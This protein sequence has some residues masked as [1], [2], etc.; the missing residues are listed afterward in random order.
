[1]RQVR[2]SV[3]AAAAAV[4]LLAGA[5]QAA[6]A[7]AAKPL[8]AQETSIDGVSAE[9]VEVMRRDGVLTVKLRYRNT[10]GAPTRV[11][12]V[13]GSSQ[14]DNY[15]VVGGK[16]KYLVLKDDKKVALMNPLSIH[17]QLWAELKPAGTFLFWA[18]YPAPPA[19]VK[20]VNFHTPHG[21]PF[22]G[23]AITEAQ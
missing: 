13:D 18:K 6:R 8:Q 7:Q 20:K 19:E 10:G 4:L 17:G 22:E 21:P 3:V 1:M 12:F 15:Y 16:T 14:V 5:P 9:V 23:L 2:C 11:T